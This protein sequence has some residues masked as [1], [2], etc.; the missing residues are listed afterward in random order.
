M[1]RGH[2]DKVAFITGAATG[3]GQRYAKRLA[4]EGVDIAVIDISDTEETVDLIMRSGRLGRGYIC[5]VS[6][7][8]DI[9]A[10]AETALSDFGR[11]DILI[12]NAGIYPNVDFD[13]ISFDDWRRVMAL[14]LDALFL[15]AKKFVPGMK[16]RGWG[17]IV[18]VS[19]STLATPVTGYVHYIAS[20]GGVVGFTRALA[21]DLA[22]Y[23]ITVNAVSPS[24]VPTTGTQ[25]T[26]PR[27]EER[28]RMVANMQ[29]IKKI[30]EADDVVGTMAFLTSDDS[31][32]VTGQTIYVDGGWVRA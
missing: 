10:M 19:S 15:T 30:Q 24:L 2:K 20:K 9:A 18:N 16:E 32:F 11:C 17:R 29:A 26:E 28:F 12:N 5:D 21:S 25:I 27:S 23:G 3:I 6:S 22:A 1:G 7:H 13:D 8:K 4:E 31:S 14:N